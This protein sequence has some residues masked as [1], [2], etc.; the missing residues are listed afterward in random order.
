MTN[1]VML[2][3]CLAAGMALWA[4]KRLPENAHTTIN[5]F[6][7]NIALPALILAKIHD[8]RASRT[9]PMS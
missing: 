9:G 4:T 2:F 5:G 8:L 6:I 7:I 1:L 3:V